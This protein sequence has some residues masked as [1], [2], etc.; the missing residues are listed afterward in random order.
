MNAAECSRMN[1]ACSS[2][3]VIREF[4]N[5]CCESKASCMSRR[6]TQLFTYAYF[7]SYA[8]MSLNYS[9]TGLTVILLLRL[10]LVLSPP[11]LSAVAAR[12]HLHQT[13]L[14][15]SHIAARPGTPHHLHTTAVTHHIT[16]AVTPQHT[17]AVTPQH[18]LTRQ[19]HSTI[20][21]CNLPGG[22]SP[23]LPLCLPTSM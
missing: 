12:P 7:S 10:I 2:E 5:I 3:R 22:H 23:S 16:P 11:H 20:P 15:S 8:Y 17:T 6:V 18:A 9:L 4:Y 19:N 1:E 13:G 14:A 21:Q